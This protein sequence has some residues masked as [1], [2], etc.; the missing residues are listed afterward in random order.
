MESFNLELMMEYIIAIAAQTFG[1]SQKDKV[2]EASSAT[3]V[4]PS[5]PMTMEIKLEPVTAD[6]SSKN[7]IY[8]QA[9]KNICVR[10][11]M[12]FELI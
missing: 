3:P 9:W 2:V 4:L 11:L 6:R 1:D 10:N 8:Y 12:I 5:T 7:K